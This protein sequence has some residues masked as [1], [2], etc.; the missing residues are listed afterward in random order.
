MR[1]ESNIYLWLLVLVPI[2]LLLMVVAEWHRRHLVNR[3]AD[4][5]LVAYLMPDASALR[6]WVKV[7]LLLLA[8]ALM[9]IVVARPQMG[10]KVSHEKR[11]GIELIVA[12]DISNSMLAEDVTPNRLQ[13]SKML[14]ESLMDN[15]SKDKVGL[16]VFAGDAFVQLPITSDYVSAKMFLQNIDPSLIQLQGT[17]I[18][19]AIDISSRS[20]T[21][22]KNI[23]KA[24]IVITDGEDH[25][26][27][28]LEAAQALKSQGVK[29]FVLGIGKPEGAPI[30]VAGGGYMTD[31]NGQTVMTALNEQMCRELADAG[32]GMFMRV[33]NSTNAQRVL[34]TE[35]S[36]LQKGETSS[37]I[38]S[39]YNEQYQ[40]FALFALLLLLVE[41]C[42]SETPNPFFK[43]FR[44]FGRRKATMSVL[45]VLMTVAMPCVAQNDRHYVR[46]GNR[47]M[48]RGTEATVKNAEVDYRKALSVNASN[49]QA[50]YN[51][52]CVMMAQKK[53]SLAMEMFSKAATQEKSPTRRAMSYH[54]MG[55]IMQGQRQFDKAIEAYKSA[56]RLRPHDD[57][58]RYNLVLCQKQ[59]KNQP[60]QQGNGGG[61]G[62]DKNNSKDKNN[63]NKQ[64][65]QNDQN[66]QGQQDQQDQQAQQKS[67]EMSKENAEQ[68]LNAAMQ[69]ERATQQRMKQANRKSQQRQLQNNW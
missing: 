7:I 31:G 67:G 8:I 44:L 64:S 51:L 4:R 45:L 57:E 24:V 18:G 19:K 20:F 42:L 41:M 28:A 3:L 6:R 33:D 60:P 16:V 54:N 14:I 11:N 62:Q 15:F 55:V 17:D 43:R 12:L 27:G 65:Q 25:E 53:D 66:K 21:S 50:M 13:R 22:E 63:Q 58:T 69:E 47:Q 68:L 46:E 1:F 30:P 35:F 48:K 37:V 2:L 49:P 40:L 10:T 61:G 23:G 32:G 34:N 29:L 9:V 26:G 5:H 39:E 52:G 59:L 56:L 38:Y 36:K